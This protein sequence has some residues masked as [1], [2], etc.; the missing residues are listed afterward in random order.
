[1]GLFDW[2]KGK[3]PAQRDV[4]LPVFSVSVQVSSDPTAELNSSGQSS[5]PNKLD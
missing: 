2:I 5:F 4:S 1:M 3:K